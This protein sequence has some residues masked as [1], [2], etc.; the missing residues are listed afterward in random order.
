MTGGADSP[1]PLNIDPSAG[2]VDKALFDSRSKD[3]FKARDAIKS[4]A[5]GVPEDRKSEVARALL[6]LLEVND[7]FTVSVTMKTLSALKAPEAVPALIAKLDD[8]QH[9][10]EAM[11]ALGRLGDPGAAEAI[12]S[13][14]KVGWPA[15]TEALI[16]LGPAAESAV[17]PALRDPDAF[18]R[19]QACEVLSKI[20]TAET[21]KAMRALPADSDGVVRM[22]ANETM[23][24]ILS[25]VGPVPVS[26]G[27]KVGK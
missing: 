26:K 21:V 24:E 13:R 20:G 6:P 15:A 1:A 9:R 7:V 27:K 10:R 18:A 3:G 5:V 22:K 16:A 12:A 19:R 23:R 8:E 4:L 17:I 11:Q 2:P 14:L 25:R